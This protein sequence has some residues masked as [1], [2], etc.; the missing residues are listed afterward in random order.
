MS[1][2]SELKP[3]DIFENKGGW[4]RRKIIV[5]IGEKSVMYA[6]SYKEKEEWTE[7][8]I[9]QEFNQC[10]INHLFTWGRKI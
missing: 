10:T 6:R 5:R 2:E 3:G 1:R 9:E 7:Y 8:E 4:Q